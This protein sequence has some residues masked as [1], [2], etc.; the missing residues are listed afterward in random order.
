MRAVTASTKSPFDNAMRTPLSLLPT[1]TDPSQTGMHSAS[2]F[3]GAVRAA[4]PVIDAQR[5]CLRCFESRVFAFSRHTHHPTPSHTL[6]QAATE[7]LHPSPSTPR[8]LLGLC[9]LDPV[10]QTLLRILLA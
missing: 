2:S 8:T 7:T 4:V 3:M 5:A 10:V 1:P 9:G 6:A